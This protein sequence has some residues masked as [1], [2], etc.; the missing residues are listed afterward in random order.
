MSNSTKR[1]NPEKSRSRARLL[2]AALA[3]FLIVDIALVAFALNRP[4]PTKAES[5]QPAEAS[6]SSESEI[7]PDDASLSEPTVETVA[8]VRILAVQDGT[9]AWRATTGPCGVP[10]LPE[11]TEDSG[12]TW[13]GTSATGPT[14]VV[15]LQSIAI[16]GQQIASMIGQNS[17]DCAEM[18]VR[19]FVGGDDYAEYPD[20]LAAAWFIS[21]RDR[22]RIHAPVG[23]LAAPCSNVVSLA[24]KSATQAAVLC[25][26]GSFH[27]T[28]DSAA[29][30]RSV[31]SAPGAMNIASTSGGYVVASIGDAECAGVRIGTVTEADQPLIAAGPCVANALAPDALSGQVAIAEGSGTLWLWA[32]D[33]VGR[34]V[35]GGSTWE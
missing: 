20:D 34:S 1:R 11:F 4:A 3:V 22:S 2:I 13:Q 26:D 19:T 35:D 32:G 30:W 31:A 33:F 17:A 6:P 29:S 10:A 12:E 23:E 9:R 5:A 21:S 28:A 8:P 15:S 25:A 27:M 7:A 14:G 18:L 16:E 24:V